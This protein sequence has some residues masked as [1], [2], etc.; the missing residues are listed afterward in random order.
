[1][2]LR[3]FYY[4]PALGGFGDETETSATTTSAAAGGRAR[5]LISSSC[6]SYSS[7]KKNISSSDENTTSCE[8]RSIINSFPDS[9]HT[10]SCGGGDA[11]AQI[12]KELVDNAVDACNLSSSPQNFHHR[13]DENSGSAAPKKVT[14]VIDKVE[15]DDEFVKA[16]FAKDH[17][18][19]DPD[20]YYVADAFLEK[21]EL[22]HVVVS[23]NGCGME[24]V[25]KCVSVFSSN[26]N[27]DDFTNYN[28]CAAAINDN[29]QRPVLGTAG[30]YGLGLTL[31]I[32][33]AQR[34][35]PNSCVIIQSTVQN[36]ALLTKFK[37]VVDTE[38]DSVVCVHRENCVKKEKSDSGTSVSLLLPVSGMISLL[39]VFKTS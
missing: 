26:K 25:E 19:S 24:D 10:A 29:S 30:R 6:S 4:N 34:L 16:E 11:F 27:Q 7:T 39:L 38:R 15:E 18:G 14:V 17:G 20:N 3:A 13:D 28:G 23:D 21:R 8:A 37:F 2:A 5:L 35:V 1:M 12:I 33:H 32:L 31:C 9:H 36:S 22:L